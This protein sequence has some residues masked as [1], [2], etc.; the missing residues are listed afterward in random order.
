[1][2]HC[3]EQTLQAARSQPG[4]SRWGPEQARRYHHYWRDR[5]GAWHHNQLPMVAGTRPK[6]FLDR[7]DNAYLIFG[8]K[9]DASASIPRGQL[10]PGVLAIAAAT[11][12]SQWANWKVI[13]IEKGPFVNEML[14]DLYRWKMDGILSIMV[15][16]A[17]VNAHDSTP[18]R[19]LDFSFEQ[20]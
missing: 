4:Q 10:A 9:H 6:V 19:I 1:M 16:E 2:W 7:K 15:Q 8:V 11:A 13:H 20:N 14:G 12:N 3:T 18:L 5:N 17:P